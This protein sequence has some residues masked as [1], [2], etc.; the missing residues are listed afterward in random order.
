MP[1]DVKYPNAE[2]HRDK[3]NEIINKCVNVDLNNNYNLLAYSEIEYCIKNEEL[4]PQGKV[5][6]L[7]I[8]LKVISS[9]SFKTFSTFLLADLLGSF[10]RWFSSPAVVI[11]YSVKCARMK[12][13]TTLNSKRNFNATSLHSRSNETGKF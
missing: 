7:H 10:S 1:D 8:K 4:E 11:E 9:M 13:I 12:I 2:E 5:A 6:Y 3:Y